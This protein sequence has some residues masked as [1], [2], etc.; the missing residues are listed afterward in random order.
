V[1]RERE[2]GPNILKMRATK[3]AEA[4]PQGDFFL[5]ISKSEELSM[6]GR[7][8]VFEPRRLK[9]QR[10]SNDYSKDAREQTEKSIRRR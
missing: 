6:T 9:A 8:F 4:M 3:Q 1:A 7:R 10:C 2:K 5:D